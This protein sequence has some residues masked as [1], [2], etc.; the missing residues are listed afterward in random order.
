MQKRAQL[1]GCKSCWLMYFSSAGNKA[2]S[3]HVS[4]SHKTMHILQKHEAWMSCR[5]QAPCL[6]RHTH[7]CSLAWNHGSLFELDAIFAVDNLFEPAVAHDVLLVGRIYEMFLLRK[8]FSLHV[9]S[10]K[11]EV[12][13]WFLK[14]APQMH[15]LSHKSSFM[16]WFR[17]PELSPLFTSWAVQFYNKCV[18]M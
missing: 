15:S 14:F 18:W 1:C 5:S 4:C 11:N 2:N 7:F 3:I 8:C 6:W 9:Q 13:F 12:V 16:P 10:L 17:V